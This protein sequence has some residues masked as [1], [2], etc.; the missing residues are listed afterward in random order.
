MNKDNYKKAINEVH[1]SKDLK[2]KTINKIKEKKSNKIVY[3]RLISSVAV[4]A[5]IFSIGIFEL[6]YLKR[7]NISDDNKYTMG[8]NDKIQI[9]KEKNDLPRF[10]SMEEL[11]NVLKENYDIKRETMVED[12][13][14]IESSDI[15]E[16]STSKIDYS[17]TNIQVENVDEAD[18]VKT[19]GEF[20]YYVV[21][22]KVIIINAEEMKEIST[23]EISKEKERFSPREIFIKENKLI[24]LG[25]YYK[26]EE[27]IENSTAKRSDVYYDIARIKTT[28]MAKAIVYDVSDKE[29]LKVIREVCLDGNYINSRMIGDNIYFISTKSVYYY[30]GIK[31]ED[32]LPLVK[33]SLETKE[34]KTVN[35][36]DIVYFKDTDY[37]SYMLVGGFN[38][39][40]SE[41]LNIETFWGASSQIYASEKN[42]YITKTNYSDYRDYYK[43]KTTIYKFDL[44]NSHISLKAKGE[45]EGY[46][47]NQFSMDEYEGKLRVA[48]N[49]RIKE[50]AEE[51]IQNDEEDI[52]TFKQTIDGNRLYVLDE[53]LKEI[54]RI[55][56]LAKDEKIYAVRFIGKYGYIVTFK[57]IDPLFVIDLSDP[58]NP[59]IKGELKIPGYSA[60]LHPYDENHI[61]GI[62]YNTKDNGYGGITNY[63]MKMSMFDV[64]DA[65]NP[66][67]IFNI[68]IGNSYTY[69]DILYNHK[70]LF[71]KKADNLIGITVG[72]NGK[73]TFELFKIDLEKGFEEYGRIT[74]E[75]I[76]SIERTIYIENTLYSLGYKNI[77]S[78]N[79][80]NLQKIKE[81]EI[82]HSI[83]EGIY[84]LYYA[85]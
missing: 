20:I 7:N 28:T 10:K 34:A 40:N 19:D 12:S 50:E 79:L 69:S 76:N 78:Y 73:N 57:Q 44:N 25:N 62:G 83:D 23:I 14:Q 53:E 80:E 75:N 38:I 65:E 71:Y 1:A 85:E 81:L 2:E 15:K 58:T 74:G 82:E 84:D 36:S 31:D 9:A 3:I 37:N 70:S 22:N 60:Y 47:N 52:N 68:D 56:N 35:Y 39:N 29:N 8:N 11:K 46:L 55:D 43:S 59:Q 54:G 16:K 5:L 41:P 27:N 51:N 49:I 63:N 48:T 21:G 30:E 18:T 24:V 67:E 33:D 72:S 42:L 13:V 6:N 26:Y 45:V 4:F 17:T 77:I 61:I 32:I 66:K 64:S